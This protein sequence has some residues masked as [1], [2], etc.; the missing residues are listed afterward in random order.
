MSIGAI[1]PERITTTR[2]EI[3]RPRASDAEAIFARYACDP[4]VTKYL[5]WRR[6][7]TI[8]DT[9]AFIDWCEQEWRHGAGAAYLVHSRDDGRLVGG[10]GLE[11]ETSYRAST[12]YVFERDAWGSGFATEVLAAMTD[13]AF[14]HSAIHRVSLLCHVD[15]GASARVA[16]KCGYVREGVL[17]KY[18]VFP[19]LRAEPADVVMFSRTR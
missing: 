8:D 19:N 11:F 7:R 3:R 16:E 15:H 2:L 10:T 4:D 18:L 5:G 14:A 1:L 13:V 17:R 12:G 9:R 6:H